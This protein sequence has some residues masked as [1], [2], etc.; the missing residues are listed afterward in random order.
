MRTVILIFTV[1]AATTA[2]LAQQQPAKKGDKLTITT[3]T[4][5]IE[6]SAT[7]KNQFTMSDDD[8]G[9]YRLTG[10]DVREFVG[11]RVELAGAQPK[12][13]IK[14]GLYPTPNVAGQAGAMDPTR[15]AVAA[16]EAGPAGSNAAPLPEFRVQSIK[17]VTGGCATR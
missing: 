11:K 4:G 16:A 3:L 17:P 1:L 15:A 12:L 6:Q 7:A 13:V 9:T 2:L 8:A 10:K 14:G 5:C